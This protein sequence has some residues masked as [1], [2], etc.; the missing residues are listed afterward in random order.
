MIF[1]LLIDWRPASSI[2]A[3]FRTKTSSIILKKTL[4][5]NEVRD[6]STGSTIFDCNWKSIEIWVGMHNLVLS[7]QWVRHSPNTLPTI[8]HDQAFH[9]VTW[10]SPFRDGSS[11]PSPR[12]SWVLG[13]FTSTQLF[14]RIIRYIYWKE[15]QSTGI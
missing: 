12:E 6:G 2:T 5:R 15:I 9:I 7:V 4:Y 11:Y 10:Q 3:I 1:L 13:P 8:V 14:N